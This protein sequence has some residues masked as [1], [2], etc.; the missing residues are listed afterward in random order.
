VGHCHTVNLQHLR[1]LSSAP[2]GESSSTGLSRPLVAV[3]TTADAR[4]ACCT[5]KLAALLPPKANSDDTR[6]AGPSNSPALHKTHG[7][8]P[9]KLSQQCSQASC[10]AAHTTTVCLH[11][12][13]SMA[14]AA[15]A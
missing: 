6:A 7:A 2:V 8:Q 11:V 13:H 10:C 9:Q 1:S 14:R 12:V 3:A 5:S 15:Q 4:P